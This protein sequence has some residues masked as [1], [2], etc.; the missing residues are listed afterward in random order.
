MLEQPGRILRSH[1]KLAQLIALLKTPPEVLP[2]PEIAESSQ[3]TSAD[4]AAVHQHL[5]G[6]DLLTNHKDMPVDK[7]LL[8]S[9]EPKESQVPFVLIDTP[10]MESSLTPSAPSC[11][12]SPDKESLIPLQLPSAPSPCKHIANLLLTVP[13]IHTRVAVQTHS[14]FTPKPTLPQIMSAPFR[15]LLQGMDAAPKFNGTPAHLIPFLEDVN[16]ITDHAMLTDE[17]R[18]K[19][20]LRYAPIEEAETWEMLSEAALPNW[21]KFIAVVK[22][23]YPGCKGNRHFTCT[24]LENLCAEQVCMLMTSQEELGQYYL[25]HTYNV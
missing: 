10:S 6:D 20:V 19:A 14:I 4:E 2:E 5:T 24:D 12:S 9:F 18:I 7:V 13:A 1:T 8:G 15:M 17:Q 11:Q 22:L 25:P 21:K 3:H 23:L 16:A